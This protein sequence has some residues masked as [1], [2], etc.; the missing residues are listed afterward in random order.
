MNRLLTYV[1]SVIIIGAAAVIVFWFLIEEPFRKEINEKENRIRDTKSR[2]KKLQGL[3]NEIKDK[4]KE[5]TDTKQEIFKML[6]AARGRSIERFLKELEEDADE[7]KIDLENI[8]IESVI[9]KDLYSKIPLNL[10]LSGPYFKIFDFVKRV[11]DRGKLD[12]GTSYISIQAEAKA[13][14]VEN[15]FKYIAKDTKYQVSDAFPNLRVE[16][17]G[18]MVIIDNSHLERYRTD[19][20]SKCDDAVAPGG[21]D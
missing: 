10:N 3:A 4:D 11:Q 14:P 5:I 6:C 15:L 7:S 8:R 13:D 19:T 20:L 17:N 1:I 16:L 9:I 2:I 12:F 18:E 21:T